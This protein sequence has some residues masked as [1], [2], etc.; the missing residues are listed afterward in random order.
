M[1]QVPATPAHRSRSSRVRPSLRRLALPVVAVGLLLA[2]GSSSAV[3]GRVRTVTVTHG[4]APTPVLVKAPA[5]ATPVGDVRYFAY[6]GT[7]HAKTVRIF[8]TMTTVGT[9]DG[10]TDEYRDTRIVF[11]WPNRNDQ[12]ILE[13]V[14]LYPG[15]GSTLTPDTTVKRAIVGGSGIFA[16]ATGEVVTTHDAD[17]TWKHVFYIR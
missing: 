13:G 16:G 9:A 15:A 14:G 11:V 2:V 10:T 8:A 3:A 6:T 7:S 12:L 4:P 1:P 5:G 17:G